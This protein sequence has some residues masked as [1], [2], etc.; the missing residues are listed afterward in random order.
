[1]DSSRRADL[2]WIHAVFIELVECRNVFY[3]NVFSMEK[4]KKGKFLDVTDKANVVASTQKPSHP[5]TN[6]LNAFVL[7]K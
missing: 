6:A 1:M 5:A 2:E 4:G 7:F 3:Q